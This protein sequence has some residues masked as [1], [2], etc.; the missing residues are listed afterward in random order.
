[1]LSIKDMDE[2]GEL[3]DGYKN[4]LLKKIAESDAGSKFLGCIEKHDKYNLKG[5]YSSVAGWDDKD[6]AAMQILVDYVKS[7]K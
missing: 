6:R 4:E 1:M 3:P 2:N 5:S 7:T